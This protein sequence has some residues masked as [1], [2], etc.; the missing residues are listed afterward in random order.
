[1][2]LFQRIR[3]PFAADEPDVAAAFAPT[4]ESVGDLLRRQRSE[5]GLN[6]REIAAALKIK[7][8][9][10]IAIE[11]GHPDQLPGAPYAIGFVRSYSDYLRLDSAAVLRRFKLEAAGLDAKPDLAFPMPLGER[12]VPAGGILIIAV[13]LAICGYGVWYSIS[14]ADRTLPEKVS[15]IPA[16]LLE[17]R[18]KSDPGPKSPPAKSAETSTNNSATAVPTSPAK[19][20]AETVSPGEPSPQSHL[21]PTPSAS[22][23]KASAVAISPPAPLSDAPGRP[24]LPS[25]RPIAAL[26]PDG[27]ARSQTE[28]ASAVVSEAN[29]PAPNAMAST[30]PVSSAPTLQNVSATPGN[31]GVGQPSRITLRA[32][33]TS[34]VQVHGPDHSILFTGFLKPGDTY[35]VPDRPGLSMR[36]GNAGGLDVLVDAKNAPALGPI[37]AVRSIALDPQSLM[38]QGSTHN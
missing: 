34:W 33:A 16:G 17:P 12:G 24:A 15:E 4:E 29:G 26:S 27:E 9:Y 22:D 31:A 38:A 37:G 13:I 25:T 21:S 7:P 10:L 8:A 18:P 23:A 30:R 32:N 2:P 5:M 14:T 6:L 28:S 35:R 20:V 1:M 3:S 36:T 11:E 19:S